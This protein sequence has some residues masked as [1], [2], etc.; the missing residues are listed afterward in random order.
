M[1]KFFKSLAVLLALTLIVGVIPAAAADPLKMVDEKTLYLGGSQGTKEDGTNCK[2]SYKKKV[3]NMITGF[4]ADTMNVDLKSA[5][6]SIV[7]TTKAGRIYAKS[8]GTTTVTVTVYDAAETEIFKKD[9]KVKVKKNATEVAVTGIAD[10]DKVK[11]GQSVDVALPR[12]G[13]D[14]DERSF[15]VDKPELAE[16]TAGE[17]ARTWTVKFLKAGEAT[18]TARAYQSAKYPGKTAEA[19][20]KV[21][22]SNPAPTDAKVV[23]SNAYELTFDTDVEAAGLFKNQSDIANDACYYMLNETKVTFSAVKS[24]KA[25][26]NTVKVTMYDN[27]AAGT[28]Y[29]VTVNECEPIALVIAGTAA[30][31][32]DSIAILTETVTVNTAAELKVALYNKDGV[33]ITSSVGTDSVSFESSNLNSYVD[34]NTLNMYNVDDETTVTATFKYYDANNNYEEVK[35]TASKKIK[36]VAEAS[37][38]FNGL[39]YSVDGSNTIANE[40]YANAKNYVSLSDGG[41]KFRAYLKIVK[42]TQKYGIVVNGANTFN[43]HALTAKIPEESIALLTTDGTADLDLDG[44]ND[45]LYGIQPNQVGKT[46][47]FIGYD[48]N[49]TFKTVAVAPIEVREKRYPATLTIKPTKSNLNTTDLN[50]NSD[51]TDDDKLTL[52]AEI[53][54]QF[55][56][57]IDP[58]AGNTG[59]KTTQNTQS[60]NVVTLTDFNWLPN[61]GTG[62]YKLVVEAGDITYPTTTKNGNVVLTTTLTDSNSK[63]GTVGTNFSVKDGINRNDASDALSF[64]NAGVS[65][66]DTTVTGTTNIK[67][68]SIKAQLSSNG[69]FT[70]DITPTWTKTVPTTANVGTSG[71]VDTFTYDFQLVIKKNNDIVD[72]ADLATPGLTNFL[73]N[74]GKTWT[75][76]NFILNGNTLVK[77][78][79]ANYSFTIYKIKKGDA[80]SKNVISSKTLVVNVTDNQLNPTFTQKAEVATAGLAAAP[81]YDFSECFKFN[82]AGTEYDN[83]TGA[84]TANQPSSNT[85][86]YFVSKCTLTVSVAVKD[87]DGTNLGDKNYALDCTINKLIKTKQ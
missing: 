10:G 13:V 32:V 83:V 4:D 31:D 61:G 79:K 54:D 74:D 42:G 3:A 25:T 8:I 39:V 21:T 14:T 22:I 47:V 71:A 35:K 53:K 68:A 44:K 70:G 30:K 27:F 20:I 87:V 50:G 11:V 40:N 59:I 16:I 17:K 56:D 6:S 9:L 24:V 26:G 57:Y 12:Q 65:T 41:F 43:G 34:G 18:F 72:P 38:V 81:T 58:A 67:A 33:D 45:G 19:T 37:E 82:F 60:A 66:L 7:K 63:A 51:K 86:A 29:Y 75:L 55:Q 48:D 62:K 28:T 78:P 1:R 76:K 15:T 84:Y 77:L 23:A 2:V 80:T 52:E 36:A 73:T 69:F 64:A 49:G 85:N 46:N 5:D